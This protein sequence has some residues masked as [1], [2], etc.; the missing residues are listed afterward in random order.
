[1]N[2]FFHIIIYLTTFSTIINCNAQVSN[3]IP[4]KIKTKVIGEWI[5]GITRDKIARINGIGSG[6]VSVI[7]QQV[8]INDPDIDLMRLV[9]TN[10][11]KKRYNSF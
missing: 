10:L 11:R 2:L 8:K 3:P 5:Q 7:I 4:H 6:S 1:M 9:A